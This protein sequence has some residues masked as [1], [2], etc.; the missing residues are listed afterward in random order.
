MCDHKYRVWRVGSPW[1]MW[2]CD[3]GTGCGRWS[4]WRLMTFD[5]RYRI[6]Y[7]GITLETGH[8]TPG[9]SS[10]MQGGLFASLWPAS[11]ADLGLILG[12]TGA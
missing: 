1:R 8:V 9:T 4:S 11:L 6:W 5:H 3:P 10:G 12:P 2:M 7:E